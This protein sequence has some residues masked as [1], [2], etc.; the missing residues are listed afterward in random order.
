[1]IDTTKIDDIGCLEAIEYLYAWL[2][3][4]LDG[5]E[6]ANDVEYHISHCK[7]CFS[8]AEME[9]ALTEH[10]RRS[11]GPATGE[12]GK[13][14]PRSPRSLQTRLEDLLNKL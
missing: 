4:E 12:D 5:E 14:A 6:I 1:M 8:R 13:K 10:I 7:S 9:K 11:T 2:D 3:G